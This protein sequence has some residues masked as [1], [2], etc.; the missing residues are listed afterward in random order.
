MGLLVSGEQI[1]ICSWQFCCFFIKHLLVLKRKKKR[2]IS[3]PHLLPS[4]IDFLE[5]VIQGYS[6][7]ANRACGQHTHDKSGYVQL[8]QVW[9][10][11]WSLLSERASTKGYLNSNKHLSTLLI[12]RHAE[13]ESGE[14]NALM[15]FPSMPS[16]TT[17]QWLHYPDFCL[18]MRRE[19]TPPCRILF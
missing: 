14:F 1:I 10:V 9:R 16:V 11:M 19:K 7:R 2:R 18:M 5:S 15:Q 3:P 12:Q 8:H 6:C 17:F 13:W 4:I